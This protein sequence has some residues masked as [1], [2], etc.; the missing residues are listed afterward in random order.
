MKKSQ[1][2]GSQKKD[3]SPCILTFFTLGKSPKGD[4]EEEIRFIEQVTIEVAEIKAHGGQVSIP[5]E[6]PEADSPPK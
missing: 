6:W 5:S 3:V 4:N 2:K 1:K